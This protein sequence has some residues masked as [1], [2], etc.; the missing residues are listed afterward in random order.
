MNFTVRDILNLGVLKGIKI[1]AGEEGLDKRVDFVTVFDAPD[2]VG[3]V[4]GYEFVIT[5]LYVFQESADQIKLI[6]DLA[7]K[8]VSALGIKLNRY[9]SHLCQDVID[10]ADKSGLPLLVIPNEKAWIDV[11]NPIMAEILNKQLVLLE[12]SN[13]LRRSFTQQVL[14]GKKIPSITKLLF[15]LTQNPVTIVELVNKSVFTWPY[16]FRHHLNNNDLLALKKTTDQVPF[17]KI[18]SSVNKVEGLVFPI[19]VAKKIEGYIIVWKTKELKELDFIA[20]EHAITVVALYIQKLKAVN[21]IDQRFKDDF[22][23]QLLQ[24]EL[25][26]PFIQQKI[27]KI[28]W[29]MGENSTVIV[30]KVSR[31]ENHTDIWEKNRLILNTIKDIVQFQSDNDVLIGLFSDD[32]IICLVSNQPDQAIKNIEN[33]KEQILAQHKAVT[34]EIGVGRTYP[35]FEKIPVSFKEGGIACQLSKLLKKNCKYADLGPYCLMIQLMESQETEEYLKRY[36]LPIVNY[37]QTNNT[38]LF[39]TLD[40]FIQLMCNYRETAKTLY[41]HHN[42]IRY[43]LKTIEKI[44]GLNLRQPE[45]IINI[46]LGL[47]IYRLKT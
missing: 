28:G 18:V 17:T 31:G 22:I 16:Y 42:T 30:I 21:E 34:I 39:K 11:I 25:S 1:A 3:W 8:N 2:A 4:R 19:E 46:M 33:A 23:R 24:G 47:K 9:V 20:I 26:S 10:T 15:E 45:E 6:S 38:D 43:R 44:I 14:E 13:K 35:G 5:T 27:E 7:K 29:R 32:T 40:T 12:K 36:I 41:V 37:D